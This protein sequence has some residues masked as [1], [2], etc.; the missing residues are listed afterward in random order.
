ME[1][2]VTSDAKKIA[3]EV[4]SGSSEHPPLVILHGWTSDLSA[5]KPILDL[6]KDHATYAWNARIH[7]EETT[8]E[9]M[10]CD[11]NELI[12]S[13]GIKP[14]LIGHSM[15]TLTILEYVRQFGTDGIEKI[16]MIDQSPKLV[17]DSEWHNG[18]YGDFSQDDNEKLIAGMQENFVEYLIKIACLG[19][20]PTFRKMY[21]LNDPILNE[22]RKRVSQLNPD[23]FI[24]TWKSFVNKDYR[25]VLPKI[26]VPVLATFGEKSNFYPASLVDYISSS[27]KNVKI[28]IYANGS[29]SPHFENPQEFV[30]DLMSFLDSKS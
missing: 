7:N 30:S 6:L 21:L 10:A 28:K 14:V 13:Y 3:L 9:R 18:L 4:T 22:I 1:H 2:F 15:G 5:W 11:L 27:I 25:D 17:C 23:Y 8:I 16:V 20:N 26:D 12:N 19:G 29:H 24:G